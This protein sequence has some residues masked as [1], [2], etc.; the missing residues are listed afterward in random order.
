MPDGA[1]ILAIESAA[2][3]AL[4]ASA[5]SPILRDFL[6]AYRAAD[7]VGRCPS[8]QALYDAE[9]AADD[10]PRLACD[11]AEECRAAIRYA[12]RDC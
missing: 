2:L 7:I 1:P 6:T 5:A 11:L 3:D 4:I 8:D 9:D 10:L 12:R